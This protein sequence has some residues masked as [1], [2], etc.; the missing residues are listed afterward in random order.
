MSQSWTNLGLPWLSDHITIAL[1][2]IYLNP[3]DDIAYRSGKCIPWAY[4]G[5][6]SAYK[7]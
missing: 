7:V 2:T 5:D 4:T 1:D 3:Y 6:L